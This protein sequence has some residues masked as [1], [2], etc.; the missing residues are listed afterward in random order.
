MKITPKLLGLTFDP[1]LT[2]KYHPDDMWDAK[3]N[4]TI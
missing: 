1:K 4:D 2:S 3:G